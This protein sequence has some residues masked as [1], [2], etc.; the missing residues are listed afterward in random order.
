MKK[1]QF[2]PVVV[3][4][5]ASVISLHGGA[6]YVFSIF[7]ESMADELNYSDMFISL[8]T[9]FGIIGLYFT[10][11]PA[12]WSNDKFGP[13][14][15]SF[16]GGVV[17]GICYIIMSYASKK[18]WMI[19]WNICA[20][21]AIGTSFI[22]ALGAGS[23]SSTPETV[24]TT[25][26]II[27]ACTSLSVAYYV[28][29]VNLYKNGKESCK[30]DDCWRS[31]IKF[32]GI[33]VL[34]VIP[35]FS[36]FLETDKTKLKKSLKKK[37]SSLK[38]LGSLKSISS[39]EVIHKKLKKFG[40]IK[41]LK[42]MIP[43]KQTITFKSSLRVFKFPSFWF[44]FFTFMVSVSSG[45]LV[46]SG[47]SKLWEQFSKDNNDSWISWTL[48][49][50]SLINCFSCII[51]GLIGDYLKKK[52]ITRNKY[53]S[54]VMI[55]STINFLIMAL[56]HNIK[57][58]GKT[59]KVFWLLTVSFCGFVFGSSFAIVP[60]ITSELYGSQNFGIIYGYFQ[61]ASS[62]AAF[63]TPT[64]ISSTFKSFNNLLVFEYIL[65]ALNLICVFMIWFV[66]YSKEDIHKILNTN[67]TLTT[68]E[69]EKIFL[70]EEFNLTDPKTIT[71][72]SSGSNSSSEKGIN[73]NSKSINN[74]MSN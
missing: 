15:S 10:I 14:L 41:S 55:I 23:L 54:V 7:Y 62:A 33:L 60:T 66:R 28:Q 52:N 6:P 3:I 46:L 56:F 49:V 73:S 61:I 43:T 65:F 50:F 19:F 22:S 71:Q 47:T 20:S 48:T 39:F 44:I 31:S 13:R 29:I 30:S 24:G 38:S 53:Y 45:I 59:E 57:N 40:S 26:S 72:S 9:S 70:E 36:L 5:C 18:G 27:G 8:L 1:F 67:T 37:L 64:I 34:I 17:A 25:I 21:F 68:K 35:F 69:Q 16:I 32:V 4:I 12:G 58:P 11:F 51:G 2:P 74:L 63:I 42:N